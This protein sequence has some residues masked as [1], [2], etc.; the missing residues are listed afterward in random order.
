MNQYCLKNGYAVRYQDLPGAN[1]T[2]VFLHGLGCASS[3]EYPAVLASPALCG[4]RALLIDLLG[5]G[6][7]D[8]PLDFGYSV[9]EHAA[10]LNDMLR[11]FDLTDIVIFGHSLGGAVAICLAGLLQERISFLILTESNLDASPP[12][13]VSRKI[14]SQSSEA[15]LSHGYADLLTRA[16]KRNPLWGATLSSWL[17]EA[18]WRISRSAMRGGKPSWR[19]QLYDLALP[20]TYLFG[21]HSLPREDVDVLR[22]HGIRVEIIPDAGHSMALENPGALAQVIEM[23]LQDCGQ[24]R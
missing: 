1:P 12:G 22:E 20:R 11:S 6:Y 23:V 4:R 16:Q 8:K 3:F 7:S 9:E 17:P 2:L 19:Q 13:A 21:A 14:G 24:T 18:A 15:F 10:Y 5:A